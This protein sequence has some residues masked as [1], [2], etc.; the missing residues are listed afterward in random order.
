V[1]VYGIRTCDTCRKSLAALRAAGYGAELR[2]LR[3]T[4]LTPDER[5][6]FLGV[7]G[8]A[9]VNRSSTTWRGLSQAGREASPDDLLAAHPTAMKRPLIV[10]RDRTGAD[11]MWLG[12]GPAVRSALVAEV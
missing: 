10:G 5:A 8:E 2:D 7:F 6:E 1:I 4:P 3:E 12:W 9:L 11:G